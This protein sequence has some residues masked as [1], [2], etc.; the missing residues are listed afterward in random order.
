MMSMMMMPFSPRDDDGNTPGTCSVSSSSLCGL[1][2]VRSMMVF[3]WITNEKY[4]ER[5][6]HIEE[7]RHHRHH[8]R[9]PRQNHALL[10][11]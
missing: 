8:H 6:S 3:L 7:H 5:S 9:L 2:E 4:A 11:I 10:D 1:R